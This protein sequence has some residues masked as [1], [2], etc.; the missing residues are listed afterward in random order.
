M[1]YDPSYSVLWN[2]PRIRREVLA[3][4][5]DVVEAH[6]PYVAAAAVLSP[7]LPSHV[8][9]TLVWHSDFV[10]TNAS[11]LRKRLPGW[12]WAL[13]RA[14][15]G[16]WAWARRLAERADA[17]LVA[18]KWQLQKLES[19][20]LRNVHLLPFGVDTAVFKPEAR[21]AKLRE[22]LLGGAPEDTKLVVAIGRMSVEKKWDD[23]FAS[24]FRAR[25]LGARARLVVLGDGPERGRL[26]A[27]YGARSDVCFLGFEK[28]RERLAATLASCDVLLHACPYETFGLGV[29]EA[30]A[31]GV[32]AVLPN[33]GGAAEFCDGRRTLGYAPGDTDEAAGHLLQLLVRTADAQRGF[34]RSEADHF[35]DLVQLYAELGLRRN[36]VRAH[37]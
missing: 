11:V 28:D 6:S 15:S 8:V 35:R 30:L 3:L 7:S 10:D 24:F 25:A 16:G 36:A 37:P 22:Q 2:I 34:V 14:E 4:A 33:E 26:Q 18:A 23:V 20:G 32:Y 17:T 29:A 19:Q 27:S 21:S 5:P 31:C 1:P 9:R 13:N 12:G